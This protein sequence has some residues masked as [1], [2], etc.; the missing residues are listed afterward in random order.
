[1]LRI[2]INALYLIPGGVGGTEIYLDNLLRGFADLNSGHEFLVYLNHESTSWFTPSPGFHAVHTGVRASF[3]PGR[4]LYE[5]SGLLSRLRADRIDL[6]LNPGFTGPARFADRSVAVFHDLQHLNH[7]EFF[8]WWDLPFWNLLLGTAARR[9]KA[10]IAVSQATASDIARYYPETAAKT[11]VIPHGTDPE[12]FRI[13]ERRRTDA[14]LI[15]TRIETKDEPPFFLTVS[16]LHPHKNLDRLLEAFALFRAQ[17]PE[18]RLV[19]AGLRGFA[20]E[21][22]ETRR[23]SLGLDGAVTFTGWI[24]R[25]ELYSLFERAQACIQPSRFEGFG[26]PVSEALSA[27]IPLACSSIPPFSEV[28]G[29]LAARFDPDSTEQMAEAMRKVSSD[30]AFRT[31]AAAEGPVHARHFSWQE[32]ARRTLQVLEQTAGSPHAR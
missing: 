26:M 6:L 4:I 1:M 9:S 15:G 7:P 13:G 19:V 32:T 14:K 29:D 16:T 22:L 11:T 30:E 23:S 2:G 12:L 31:R 27:G 25:A 28:A 8:R 18:H 24:P 3:R 20:A 21:A 10:L 17:H 5:Q